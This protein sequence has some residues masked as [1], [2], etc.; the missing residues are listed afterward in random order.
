[1]PCN[2]G[3]LELKKNILNFH[4]KDLKIPYNMDSYSE[5]KEF[6]DTHYETI[7]FFKK[8]IFEKNE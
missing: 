8:Q 2:F 1:M 3:N 7:A 5:A 6:A 4:E